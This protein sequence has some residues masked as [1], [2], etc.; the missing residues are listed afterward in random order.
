MGRSPIV[1]T[2]T[3][4]RKIILRFF[5]TRKYKNCRN[6]S[7]HISIDT[8]ELTHPRHTDKIHHAVYYIYVYLQVSVVFAT[9]VM[10]LY[11]N[12]DKI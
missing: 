3:D 6:W 8:Y 2:V 9:I 5:P 12:I 10:V 7:K 11:N 4:R 1:Q